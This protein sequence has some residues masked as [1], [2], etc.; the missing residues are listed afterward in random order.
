MGVFNSLVTHL[1]GQWKGLL[2]DGRSEQTLVIQSIRR[3]EVV[4][5]AALTFGPVFKKNLR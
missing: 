5:M 4:L 1:C 2:S 3:R